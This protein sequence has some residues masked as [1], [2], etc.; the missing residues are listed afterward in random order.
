MKIQLSTSEQLFYEVIKHGCISVKLT[1]SNEL[2]I[3]PDTPPDYM[4]PKKIKQINIQEALKQLLDGRIWYL[5]ENTQLHILELP[6][7]QIMPLEV[8]AERFDSKGALVCQVEGKECTG[9]K[10]IAA[11]VFGGYHKSMLSEL[12]PYLRTNFDLSEVSFQKM[13]RV[14]G[15]EHPVYRWRGYDIGGISNLRKKMFWLT[16]EDIEKLQQM[17]T[18]NKQSLGERR[19]DQLIRLFDLSKE[20]GEYMLTNPSDQKEELSFR[21]KKKVLEYI[22]N[23][24]LGGSVSR[25]TA[26]QIFD[27]IEGEAKWE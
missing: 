24:E 11:A 8:I 1:K 21:S 15:K 26:K 10:E 3:E 25:D 9:Y 5:W 22:R 19:A 12:G 2:L 20:D 23:H 7:V 17:V 13:R 14:K 27:T 18:E 4:V 16:A 6:K